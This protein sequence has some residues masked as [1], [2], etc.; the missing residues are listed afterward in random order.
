MAYKK[1]KKTV[2]NP[3]KLVLIGNPLHAGANQLSNFAFNGFNFLSNGLLFPIL[4]I[5]Y[6]DRQNV[7]VDSFTV[8]D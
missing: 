7:H 4:C 2:R 8:C 3:E 6:T 5:H 1:A